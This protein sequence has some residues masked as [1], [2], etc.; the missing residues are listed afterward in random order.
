MQVPGKDDDRRLRWEERTRGPLAVGAGV[1]L[2]TLVVPLYVPDVPGPLR[3]GLTAVGALTWLAFAVD[4]GVRLVLAGRRRHFVLTHPLQLLVVLAPLLQPLASL[5]LVAVAR[6]ALVAGHTTRASRA[7]A[8]GRLTATAGAVTLVLMTV[9]GGLVLEAERDAPE[10]N[11]T[12][13][14]DAVWWSLATVTTVGYGDHFPTTGAG[15]L[16]AT[17]L[18][19]VGIALLGTVSASIAAFFVDTGD[20]DSTS[21]AVEADAENDREVVR[22]LAELET[23]LRGLREELAAARG[24]APPQR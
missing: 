23:T 1:F 13:A 11:I 7:A 16:V 14:G 4:Y 15:R 6:A 3:L 12:T 17:V 5:R 18:M 19:L 22:R 8:R 2:L 9:C 10:A 21:E 24:Q 20:R